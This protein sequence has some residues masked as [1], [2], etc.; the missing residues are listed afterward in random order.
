VRQ[1]RIVM[2]DSRQ[3]A[4][5]L[6]EL[7]GV[8]EAKLRVVPL[9]AAAGAEGADGVREPFVLSVGVRDAR[10]RTAALVEGHRRY[11]EAANGDPGRCRLVLAGPPGD[12]EVA[13]RAVGSPGVDLLGFVSRAKLA[14][15]YRRATLLVYASSYEGFG[16]PVL[17][18]MAN[19]CPVLVARSS[20]LEEVGGEAALPLE[21]TTPEGIAARL[22]DVL[23]DREALAARGAAG[24]QRA[25]EFTWSRTAAETLAAYRD[26]LRR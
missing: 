5:D 17:E 20:A 9:G 18:A 21:D 23:T 16:L 8:P 13:V 15:L 24:R 26:A 2:A 6:G 3:T 25:G 10:K 7:Y 19:G 14:D 22:A 4:R 1:A 12:E 11:W